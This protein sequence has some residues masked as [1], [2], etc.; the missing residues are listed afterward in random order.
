MVVEYTSSSQ[1]LYKETKLHFQSSSD[2]LVSHEAL[3]KSLE[4]MALPFSFS[5]SGTPEGFQISGDEAAVTLVSKVLERVRRN[6]AENG[7]ADAS[8]LEPGIASLVQKTLKRDLAFRLKG[9]PYAIQ[10]MSLSQV[11]FMHTLLSKDETFIIGIGPTGTGKTHI[12]IAAALNQLALE[13]V[14]HI[15]ITRPHVF[16]DGEVITQASREEME[17]DGQFD[18][19]E[20]ILCD[21][22]GFKQFDQLIEQRKL[23]IT[24]LGH[25]RGRTFNESFII[26]DDAQNMTVRKMRMAVTRIGRGSRL[27]VTGDPAQVDLRGDEPSG[28]AHLLDLIQGT[29]IATIH[30]FATDQIIRNRTAARLEELYAHQDDMPAFAA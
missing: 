6:W 9:L 26:I 8:L 29:D 13:N 15:V 19:F 5:L 16:R 20:D 28:L 21:L 7:L 27:V 10:P 12:A 1:E 4:R 2:F 3:V 14:K 11:A 24:P 30:R 17:R 18:F 22:V 25:M 23:E